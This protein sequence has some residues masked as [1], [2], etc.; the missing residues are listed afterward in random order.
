[1]RN[2]GKWTEARYRTF[3]T[4]VLRA[5]SRKWPPKY[6]CLNDA[7]TSKKINTKTK[8]MAQHYLCAS[9][10]QEY[11]QSSVQVDHITPVIDVA[12]GF[13]SWDDFIRRLYCEKDNLQVLCVSCHSEKT[14]KEKQN[15]NAD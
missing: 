11:P 1:M 14:L 15:G 10:L 13:T 2:N 12:A 8:R 9:C 7:K 3:I 5:G 4:S 6:E